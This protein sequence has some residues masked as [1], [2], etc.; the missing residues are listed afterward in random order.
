MGSG[1]SDEGHEG[2]EG[3]RGGASDEGH[4]G[5][6]SCRSGAGDEGNEGEEGGRG[7]SD[8]GHEGVKR[9]V[10]FQRR[11]Q[12]KVLEALISVSATGRQGPP[13]FAGPSRPHSRCRL[14]SCGE[15][16]RARQ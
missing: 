9:S 10:V 14:D 13:G 11:L 3:G 6:E 16:R 2:E 5:K 1:T 4:E 8:E 12:C 7:T 15:L